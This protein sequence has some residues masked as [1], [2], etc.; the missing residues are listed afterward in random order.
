MNA[1]MYYGNEPN[2]G[3]S[4]NTTNGQGNPNN[5][6]NSANQY[7]PVNAPQYTGNNDH[8]SYPQTGLTVADSETANTRTE[9]VLPESLKVALIMLSICCFLCFFVLLIVK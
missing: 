2:N 3:Y 9:I 4:Y 6:R 7:I 5:N 1:N 8:C